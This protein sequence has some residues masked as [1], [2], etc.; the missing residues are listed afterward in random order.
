[1]APPERAS[2]CAAARDAGDAGQSPQ[3]A[4]GA[5]YP[6]QSSTHKT[7]KRSCPQA[8][9]KHKKKKKKVPTYYRRKVATWHTPATSEEKDVLMEEM[10]ELE[11]E[12]QRLTRQAELL[13]PRE[14]LMRRQLSNKMLRD[15]VHSQRLA[16]ARSMSMISQFFCD[17]YTG[18]FDSR[19]RLGKD[20]AER[21]AT[22][23]KLKRHRLKCAYEFMMERQRHMNPTSEFCDQKKFVATNG[24]ICSERFEI[25]PLVDARGVKPVFDALEG[26][27]CN[28]EI[29]MS[30]V[31][32]DITIRENDDPQQSNSVAQHRLV[33]TIADIVQMDTNNVAFAEYRP[34]GPPGSGEEEIGFSINDAI[35]EDELFPYRPLERVR[36]DVTVI[37]MVAWHRRKG[38]EP[39]VV[40]SRWWFLRLRRSSIHV[41]PFREKDTGPFDSLTHLGKDPVE[42]HTA[43]LKMKHE[44]VQRAYEFMRERQRFM[45]TSTE[46][47]DQKKFEATN[48]DLCSVRF[49]VVPLPAARSVKTVV[50]ALETFVF[51][52]EISISEVLGD[53][54]VRENDDPQRSSSV[55]QHRLVT[56]IADVVQMD[57]NNVAFAEYRPQGPPGSGVNEIG[58]LICDSVDEDELFPYRPSERVRQ[59]VTV[60]IMVAR[61]SRRDGEPLIVLSR[62][63]CLRIRRS[64][65]D[66]P[67]FVVNRIQSGV[68]KVGAGMMAAV[69]RACQAPL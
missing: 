37:I 35:D 58:F 10:K 40:L 41:P 17:K 15:M 36:Q 52:I 67:L 19:M 2:R 54:T 8:Q 60:I 33:T 34:P 25:V 22:L 7:R 68:E 49:E 5:G 48:G 20:P 47:C 24:D 61:H 11:G 38:G 44:R 16:F 27:V 43:L 51:N 4:T 46:F 64:D 18:P 29:G 23:L 65:I 56:T 69:H 62:W 63:W 12:M 53:I 57:T 13:R 1:M 31:S 6:P 45:D 9:P 39:V 3:P 26:F 50:D 55:A 28:A 32:G 30:E 66:V 21:E 59:D 14:A 42:R